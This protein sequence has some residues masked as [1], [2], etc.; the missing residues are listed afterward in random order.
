MSVEFKNSTV[1]ETVFSERFPRD[2]FFV[3]SIPKSLSSFLTWIRIE[4]EA[5]DAT[6]THNVCGRKE[7]VLEK[8]QAGAA[9]LIR[10]SAKLSISLETIMCPE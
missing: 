10:S 6:A 3:G 4:A 9:D 1:E 8:S 7:W 5:C 2:Y